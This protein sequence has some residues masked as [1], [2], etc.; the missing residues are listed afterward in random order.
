MKLVDLT[1]QRFGRLTVIERAPNVGRKTMWKCKCDCGNYTV[2]GQTD[3]HSQRTKS[4]GCMF[5]EQLAERNTKHGL[6]N[7]RLCSIWRAMKGRCD[8]PNNRAYKNYGGRGIKVC[9]EW[10]NDLQAFYSWAI[11]NGYT[12]ELSIDRIDVNGN[13]C[14]E[15]CRWASKKVQANNTRANRYLEYNGKRQTIAQWGAETGVRPATIR[16]RLELGWTIENALK[17]P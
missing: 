3:L 11:S 2:V 17:T 8:N 10:E 4:C 5:K 6:S 13:Y 7:T 14:P 15:N 16:R 1:G 9:A 12:D